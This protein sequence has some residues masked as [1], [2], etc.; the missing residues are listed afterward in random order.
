MQY[1]FQLYTVTVLQIHKFA[2]NICVSSIHK[3]TRW[4]W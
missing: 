1:E 4:L 2:L 3:N